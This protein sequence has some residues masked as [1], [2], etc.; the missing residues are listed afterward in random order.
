MTPEELLRIR[1]EIATEITILETKLKIIHDISRILSNPRTDVS[2]ASSA[3]LSWNRMSN[4]NP[5]PQV[6]GE[7]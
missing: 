5:V 3:V 1:H 7:N 4:K 2:S 6:Q